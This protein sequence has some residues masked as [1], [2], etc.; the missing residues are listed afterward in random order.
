M[1]GK[2]IVEIIASN[3]ES[4]RNG[5]DKRRDVRVGTICYHVYSV[6]LDF[7]C[8]VSYMHTSFYTRVYKDKLDETDQD[9]QCLTDHRNMD[10]NN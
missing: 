5:S 6:L 9:E 3:I 7:Q 1:T 4:E 10:L 2:P 8:F